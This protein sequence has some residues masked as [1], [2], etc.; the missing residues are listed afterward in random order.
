M[1][2]KLHICYQNRGDYVFVLS[3]NN[4]DFGRIQFSWQQKKAEGQWIRLVRCWIET[5]YSPQQ[6]AARH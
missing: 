1:H 3:K 2:V 4:H 5:V 6:K